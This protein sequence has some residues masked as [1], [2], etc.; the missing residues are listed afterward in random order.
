ML[1]LYSDFASTSIRGLSEVPKDAQTT[2]IPWVLMTPQGYGVICCPSLHC[3]CYIILVFSFFPRH[4]PS[5]GYLRPWNTILQELTVKTKFWTYKI[6]YSWI[7]W[8]TSP[9]QIKS[10]TQIQWLWLT[11]ILQHPLPHLLNAISN[12]SDKKEMRKHEHRFIK[13]LKYLGFFS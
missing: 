5:V 1:Y 4:I 13:N 8:Q 9:T 10:C 11:L 3:R 6:A 7:Q 2:K 12:S